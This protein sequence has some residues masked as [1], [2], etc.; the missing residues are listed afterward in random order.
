MS[1]TIG[2]VSTAKAGCGSRTATVWR[3]APTGMRTPARRPTARRPGPPVSR[4]RS[5]SITPASVSTATTR[6]PPSRV[7]RRAQAGEGRPLAQL[8]ARR[9]HRE[10]IG[11]DVARRV[12]RAVGRGEAAAAM[13]VGRQRDGGRR[14]LRGIEPGHVEPGRLLHRDAL[15]PGPLVVLGHGQDQVAVAAEPGIRAVGGLLAVV[16]V[17]RP[18]P[19][20]D[21][22]RRA[23]LR[24]HDAGRPR[25]GA[26]PGQA[27]LER[28]RRA[29]ARRP[30]RRPTPSHRPSPPRRPR[31]P[32]DPSPS[33]RASP[34]GQDRRRPTRRA[35]AGLD[36]DRDDAEPREPVERRAATDGVR[37]DLEAGRLGQRDRRRVE[38]PPVRRR[39]RGSRARA[40]SRSSAASSV[41]LLSQRGQAGARCP[42]RSSAATLERRHDRVRQPRPAAR[43]QAPR[44]RPAR[45]SSL[46]STSRNGRRPTVV[47]TSARV[48]TP[49]AS[50]AGRAQRVDP[51]RVARG[52]ARASR[53]GRSPGPRRPRPGRRTR[54]RR[55]P[56]S[57]ARRANAASVFSGA[58]RQSPRWASRSVRAGT[59][60][61]YPISSWAAIPRWSLG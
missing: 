11:A 49:S 22:G 45:G 7:G 30:S 33:L 56:G 13:T 20:R 57:P 58:R 17:D 32:P 16:E 34:C 35:R 10:R 5:V 18:A 24:P 14:G 43:R 2:I 37:R 21:R 54:G 28:R 3:A 31:D 41:W 40:P 6:V 25:R 53:R 55:R 27:A 9:L 46:S 48:G 12:D 8:D 4:T 1:K 29:R 51:V 39:P 36:A 44:R 26:H 23:A 38:R 59:R 47:R 50:R 52:C 19:E 42:I 61:P 60:L 15:A